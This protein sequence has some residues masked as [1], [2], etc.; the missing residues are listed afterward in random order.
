MNRYAIIGSGVAGMAAAQAIRTD[1]PAGSVH[2][3][4][5]DPDGYYSRPGLAFLLTGEVSEG[6]LHPYQAGELHRAGIHMHAGRVAAIHPS[7]HTIHLQNREKAAYD[8]L[9]IATGSEAR[10]PDV[11]GIGLEG[12]VKL[13][14]LA[15][16]R[17]IYKQA[18][19]ARR[20]VV[21]GG[22]IIALELVEGLAAR[23]AQVTYFLR[24]ER[25]WNG[26][27]DPEES[28]IIEKRLEEQGVTILRRTELAEIC[29][30][31]GRVE[32]V[33]TK[34]GRRL[35]ADL[36]AAA[37]GIR[38]RCELAAASGIKTGRGIQVDEQLR[39][40]QADIFAAGDVAEVFDPFTQHFVQD[41]LWAP[42]RDQGRAA[43]ANMAGGACTYLRPLSMNATRLAGLAVTI[44]GAVGQD[45]D[46]DL[47][48][49]A[50]GDSEVWHQLPHFVLAEERCEF[51][52]VRLM[53]GD[54]TILGAVL[55]GDQTLSRPLEELILARANIS[56]F[57]D[58]LL[59]PGADLGPLLI[60]FWMEWKKSYAP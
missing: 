31:R 13:D 8:R 44:I 34:D 55:I 32:A 11:A 2:V 21:V 22:G 60:D 28:A 6:G 35:A 36:V 26:V 10:L 4:S 14:T 29:G 12:V 51:N 57:R 43:G 33:F 18:G 42:A 40:S 30:N 41:S 20:A 27:L 39:T 56:S 47:A 50:H 3:F 24:G 25:C 5:D 9:L 49:I 58:R 53:V 54:R 38:A 45:A 19:K 48:G 52:R 15:D 7:E 16:A 46:H 17:A 59:A 37:V 1:D 23:G